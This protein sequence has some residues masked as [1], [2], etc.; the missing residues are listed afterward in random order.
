MLHVGGASS[1]SAPV[2][3]ALDL[4]TL[5]W[6]SIGGVEGSH[7]FPSRRQRH[8][9][10]AMPPAPNSAGG[11][12]VRG[13][14]LH[15]ASRPH[16]S[17][18]ATLWLAHVVG[19]WLAHVVGLHRRGTV[20][21][22]AAEK[23]LVGGAAFAWGGEDDG[24][25]PPPEQIVCLCVRSRAGEPGGLDPA[26]HAGIPQHARASLAAPSAAA[27]AMASPTPSL[28][29]PAPHPPPPA[30][31]RPSSHSE[32]N[33]HAVVSSSGPLHSA[34]PEKTCKTMAQ[35]HS[36]N[37]PSPSLCSQPS[38]SNCGSSCSSDTGV[39]VMGPVEKEWAA[40]TSRQEAARRVAEAKTREMRRKRE[41]EAA[42]AQVC[43]SQSNHWVD[44]GM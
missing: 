4:K 39:M 13:M 36:P 15:P 17:R 2:F 16:P 33:S 20:P 18:R 19:V 25:R 1:S 32:D 5:L 12:I 41:A 3:D 42:A 6:R 31:R 11:S 37:Q 9:M 10:V 26:A 38:H 23:C 28:Q 22:A 44:D 8:A 29:S 35:M 21:N 43:A 14:P 7:L 34:C 30:N 24:V 27:A 40:W